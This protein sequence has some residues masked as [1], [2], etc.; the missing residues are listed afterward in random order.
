[1]EDAPARNVSVGSA[2]VDPHGLVPVS[3]ARRY[4]TGGMR[5]HIGPFYS[6][7]HTTRRVPTRQKHRQRT[8]HAQRLANMTPEQR[9]R[10]KV[11]SGIITA[12]VAVVVL[13]AIVTAI[14][15]SSNGPS[16]GNYVQYCSQNACVGSNYEQCETQWQNAHE[17]PG[18]MQGVE[19]LWALENDPC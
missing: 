13:V 15:Q 2:D 3:P 19:T 16:N 12:I 11:R 8:A 7:N 4:R 1:V 10:Y 5:F 14:A 17:Q 6:S 18:A 9:Q